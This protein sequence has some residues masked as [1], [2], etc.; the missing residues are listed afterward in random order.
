MS[1]ERMTKE[2]VPED[3]SLSL[4]LAD[5][6]PV[7]FFGAN[8]L[9]I[10]TFFKS[11]LFLVGAALCFLG[12]AGKVLW[13]ILVATKRINVW[14]LFLQMRILMPVGFL[15]MILAL[16]LK[17]G[18]IHMDGILRSITS[19]PSSLFFLLGIAGMILMSVF[20]IKL[21]NSDLK[22]NWIEQLTNGFSQIA[23]FIGLLILLIA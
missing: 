7:L 4:A 23:F 16:I 3:F 5:A 18:Q 21:D 6:L 15:M 22:S 13:K 17:R 10:G 19:F 14:W 8:I 1:K 9:L 20:A 12:G 11:G 2:K